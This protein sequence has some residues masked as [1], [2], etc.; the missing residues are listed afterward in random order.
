MI[1]FRPHAESLGIGFRSHRYDHELL[2]IQR[3]FR[4]SAAVY[5]IHHR[6]GK[7]LCIAAAQIT[8]KRHFQ[9]FCR[10]FRAREGDSQNG[11]GAQ[12]SLVVRPIQFGHHAVQFALLKHVFA[13]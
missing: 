3:I 5:H 9:R 4:M 13:H 1:D 10:R 8:V 6:K 11:V 2:E 7:A 12:V